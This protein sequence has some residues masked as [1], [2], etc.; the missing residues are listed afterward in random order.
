MDVVIACDEENAMLVFEALAEFGAPLTGLRPDDF[1]RPDHFY[2]MG[3]PPVRIDILTSVPG[4]DFESAW[5]RRRIIKL[6]GVEAPVIAPEDLLASKIASGRP[7]DLVDADL[8]RE[9]LDEANSPVGC[10]PLRNHSG[11]IGVT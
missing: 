3:F 9:L 11:I 10:A 6:N 5:S 2:Q 4:V 7:Q 8:L 1:M